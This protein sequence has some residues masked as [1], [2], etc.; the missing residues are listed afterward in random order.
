M[1]LSIVYAHIAKHM[2]NYEM[3]RT[4]SEWETSY[5]LKMF[6]FQFA[7]NHAVLIYTAFIR[8]RLTGRPGKYF[9]TFGERLNGCDFAGC[10]VELGILLSMNMIGRSVLD[11]TIEVYLP[12]LK[13]FLKRK[14][15]SCRMKKR[16]RSEQGAKFRWEQDFALDETSDL[17]LIAEYME[18][19]LQYSFVTMYITA[20][21]L[22]PLVALFNNLI[23]IRVDARKF[24]LQ[25]R[26]PIAWRAESIG[27]WL[28]IITFVSQLG[29]VTN[30]LL[31]AFTTQFIDRMVYM[32]YENEKT[33]AQFR[34]S[35]FNV[36]QFDNDIKPTETVLS[37]H[38]QHNVTECY[39]VGF[40]DS[41]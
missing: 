10:N 32:Q 34:L 2:T 41:Q 14:W 21:P 38:N 19:V 4:N 29:V 15:I 30:A 20:F 37:E 6:A 40:R 17:G 39:Y 18:I 22:A 31:I 11:N 33:Y 12:E 24:I 16:D 5:I 25:Q 1:L 27:I 7:N 36:S 26:R 13:L 8:E 3:P 35:L 9:R 23:E 28:D